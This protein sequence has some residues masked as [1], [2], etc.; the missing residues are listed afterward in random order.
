MSP[1]VPP[2]LFWWSRSPIRLPPGSSGP[3]IGPQCPGWGQLRLVESAV[4]RDS[5]G[6]MSP[7]A[8][9]TGCLS[10]YIGN[11]ELVTCLFKLLARLPANWI[12]S[13]FPTA[14][15]TLGQILII[16]LLSVISVIRPS[17][18][19]SSLYYIKTSNRQ[20]LLGDRFNVITA[21]FS[22]TRSPSPPSPLPPPSPHLGITLPSRTSWA[23]IKTESI[24]RNRSPE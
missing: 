12:I 8:P 19:L 6:D 15:D 16:P 18:L 3:L 7:A 23:N 4:T 9:G 20:S 1:S 17:Q 11:I 13:S 2:P 5:I 22:T 10:V 14:L 24:M 21:T